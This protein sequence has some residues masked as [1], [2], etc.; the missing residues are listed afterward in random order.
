MSFFT[1]YTHFNQ[2]LKMTALQ[3]YQ[4][5]NVFLL[6]DTFV[7]LADGTCTPKILYRFIL[8][9]RVN[10]GKRAIGIIG[11]FIGNIG[12]LEGLISDT[13]VTVKAIGPLV[14]VFVL[15]YRAFYLQIATLYICAFL[16]KKFLLL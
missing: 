6:T 1:M 9:Y 3:K 12:T 10:I 11:D 14:F 7:T 16:K 15:T 5:L 2:V 13:L 8:I 4:E